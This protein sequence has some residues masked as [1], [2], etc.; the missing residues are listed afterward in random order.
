[1]GLTAMFKLVLKLSVGRQRLILVLL[2]AIHV[3]A[4]YTNLT[5]WLRMRLLTLFHIFLRMHEQCVPGSTF[6]PQE[7]GH[8]AMMYLNQDSIVPRQ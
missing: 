5:T 2:L 3:A 1:M 4:P 8:E 7:L 6:T